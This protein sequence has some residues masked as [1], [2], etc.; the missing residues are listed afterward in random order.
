MINITRKISKKPLKYITQVNMM[1]KS[2]KNK[3]TEEKK[4]LKREK[5]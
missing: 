5:K 1:S 3:V 2:F 4:R